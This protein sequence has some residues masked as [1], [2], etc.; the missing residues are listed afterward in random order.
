MEEK[1]TYP[2]YVVIIKDGDIELYSQA[3]TVQPWVKKT[4]SLAKAKKYKNKGSAIKR[5]EGLQKIFRPR[6]GYE[7]RVEKIV[8]PNSL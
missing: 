6:D 2:F 5:M 7:I 1:I 8:E 4:I 3:S